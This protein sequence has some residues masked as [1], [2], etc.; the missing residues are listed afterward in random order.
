[1]KFVAASLLYL[2]MVPLPSFAQ[3]NLALAGCVYPKNSPAQAAAEKIMALPLPYLDKQ[4]IYY[5]DDSGQRTGAYA[6]RRSLRVYFYDKDNVPIGTAIR[7]SQ[8]VTS[9]FDPNGSYLGNC[10]NHKL[11]WSDQRPVHFDPGAR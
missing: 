3:S 1:M 11:M 9:Y 2:L 5:R 4:F 6:V 7:R 8:A 10:V